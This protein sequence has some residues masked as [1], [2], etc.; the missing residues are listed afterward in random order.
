MPVV[1]EAADAVV[2]A[3]AVADGRV[4]D[5][6]RRQRREQRRRDLRLKPVPAVERLRQG[7]RLAV[8]QRRPGRPVVRVARQ[9]LKQRRA[10]RGLPV[11]RQEPVR[12]ADSGRGQ[13][14]LAVGTSPQ[15]VGHRLAN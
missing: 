12:A 9:G 11:V 8:R 5:F 2:V 6:H 13:V 14:S 10:R 7:Q 1:V 3:V 4:A 15:A